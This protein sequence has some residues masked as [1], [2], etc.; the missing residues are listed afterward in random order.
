MIIIFIIILPRSKNVV[1]GFYKKHESRYVI[2]V[3]AVSS[4]QDV[5]QQNRIEVLHH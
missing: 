2:S 4:R 3:C 1:E 5:M